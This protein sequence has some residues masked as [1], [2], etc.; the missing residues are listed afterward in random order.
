VKTVVAAV[1]VVLVGVAVFEILMRPT[2]GERLEAVGLFVIMAVLAALAAHWLPRLPVTSR[3]VARLIAAVGLTTV[4]L[5]AVAVALGAWRM[6]LSSHDL[7]LVTAVLVFAA[8]LGVVFAV[9]VARSLTTDLEA[10]RHTAERVAA[11]DLS[12]STGI[13]RDDELGAVAAA[14]D[15]MV[16]RLAAAERQRVRDET[17]RR[18]L[19]AAVGHDLRTPLAALQA[20]IESLQDGVATDPER[21]LRSMGRDVA[22][23]SAL[24][25]DLFLLTRIETGDLTIDRQ[26]MDLSELADETIEAMAPVAS[27]EGVELRLD[28]PGRVPVLGAPDALGRVMRNLVDNA[29]RHAPEASHVRVRVANGDYA[30]VE[31]IDEGPGFPP[32]L[33][34]SVFDSFVRGEASRSRETGGAGLGLAIAR[35]VVEAHGGTI[36]VSPGPGGRVT[37]RVPAR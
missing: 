9:G 25:D 20:A 33:V 10:L 11:D 31:V 1:A 26:P 29:I 2:A 6:F 15:E 34:P 14:L 37:F 8:G 17:S 27:R 32:E 13:E 16:G 7:R 4:G 18:T 24:V 22:A 3:S 30:T 5:I 23:L 36:W 35:G 28:T 19:L 21:Y 12:Q